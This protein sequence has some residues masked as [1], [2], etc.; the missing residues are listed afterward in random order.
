MKIITGFSSHEAAIKASGEF[1]GKHSGWNESYLAGGIKNNKLLID[2]GSMRYWLLDITAPSNNPIH[3]A[4]MFDMKEIVKFGIKDPDDFGYL[5]L[6][7]GD[8][9][10]APKNLPKNVKEKDRYFWIA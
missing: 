5:Q 2:R 3:A 4:E 1:Y 9:I 8:K 7:E 6:N 10:P